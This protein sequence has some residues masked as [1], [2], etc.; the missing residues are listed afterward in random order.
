MAI[1]HL[2]VKP[3]SRKDGRSAT[4]AAAYRSAE[5]IHDE[6]TDQVFDYTRKCG[7][8]RAEIVL[9]TA[10]AKRDINWA[11]DRQ[12]LWNAAEIAEKVLVHPGIL[13]RRRLARG[14]KTDRPRSTYALI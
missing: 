1:Y 5:K 11:R 9:P 12:Q 4:A 8:E 7:V 13:G 14:Q 10:A 2:S 6:T 3:L